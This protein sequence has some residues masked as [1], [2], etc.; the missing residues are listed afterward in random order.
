MSGSLDPDAYAIRIA[1]GV[2]RIDGAG[3]RAVL[4][5]VYDVLERLG[6]R[7]FGPNVELTPTIATIDLAP[8]DVRE[9]PAFKWRGLELISGSTPGIVD[10]M[11]K[12]RLNVAW[13]ESYVPK[14]DLTPADDRMLASSIPQMRERGMSI[15]WG[16]HVLPQLMP[17]GKY[18]LHPEYFAM[19]KG[20]RLKS[21]AELQTRNQLCVSNPEA[22]RVLTENTI[23][24]LRTHPWVNV[25]FI[26]AGDTTQWCECEKCLSLLPEP[27]RLSS[28]GGFD[29]SALYT[30][31][32]KVVSEGVHRAL[33]ER[34]IAFNHYYNLENLPTNKDGTVLE[35]ALPPSFVL[36]AVDD[37]HQCDRHS[38]VDATCPQGK[39]I[40]PIAR[41]WNRYYPESVSWSYYFASNF[42]LGLP[43][44]EVYKIPADFRFLRRLGVR[45]MVDNV[46]LEPN[47]L[48]WFNNL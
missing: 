21:D 8:L 31:M 16:G 26:W 32:I 12:L 2:L 29:R 39:R 20:K 15:F 23:Q 34:R 33:P 44:S 9:K 36:S 40:E 6:C 30:R 4:Y 37:Y 41:K 38:F 14:A 46:T 3:E 25:L 13:P 5:G 17:V 1:D 28:F 48:H 19:I 18:Q 10:W 7:W 22:L 43:I 45:G 24:F 11:T 27:N 47:S 42:T 35:A